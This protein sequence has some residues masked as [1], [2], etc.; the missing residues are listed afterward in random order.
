MSSSERYPFCPGIAKRQV[1]ELVSTQAYYT[2]ELM[3]Q[4]RDAA[5]FSFEEIEHL[6]LKARRFH[7]GRLLE[8]CLAERPVAAD[9]AKQPAA[10][11][12]PA[13]QPGEF[14]KQVHSWNPQLSTWNRS[15]KE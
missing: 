2:F 4:H 5:P 3:E 11:C 10:H 14:E 8:Q 1:H 9:S 13:K 15:P 6:S 12:V 7:T